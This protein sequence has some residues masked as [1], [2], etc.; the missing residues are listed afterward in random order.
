MIQGTSENV[1][2]WD[3]PVIDELS[4][5]FK[6]VIFDKRGVGRSDKLEGDLT[7]EIMAANLL[8]LMDALNINQAHILG[9]SL[10]GMIAQEL[11]LNN[12]ERIKKLVLCSTTCGG[13]KAEMPSMATQSIMGRLASRGHTKLLVKKAMPHTFSKKF[14]DENPEFI[15]KKTNDFLIMPTEPPT[16]QAHIAAW[17]R[18]NSCRKLKNIDIPTL[19][20]HG[21]QDMIVPFSNSELLAEKLPNAEVVHFDSS[22][23]MIHSEEPDKFY[24]VLLKFLQ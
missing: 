2:T 11:A 10:G 3:H 15:E 17:G 24:D 19:I 23:H 9:H 12:P 4:K 20:M 13:S 1:Y 21:K 18:Y 22:A 14:I 8:G 7:V 6:T 16:F 5:H